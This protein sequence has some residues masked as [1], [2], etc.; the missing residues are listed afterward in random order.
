MISSVT[1]ALVGVEEDRIGL[2]VGPL[3]C[4]LLVPAV[5]VPQLQASIGQELTLFTILY[6]A[7]DPSRGS[8]EPTLIG[9]LRSADKQFF[10][11]FTTVKGIGPRKALRALTVQ[12]GEIAAAIEEKDARYLTRLEGIGKRMAE[13]IIAELA[14][15]V[16]RFVTAI[17]AA[18]AGGTSVMPGRR[19]AHEEDAIAAM[20]A[21]GE[22]RPDAEH[23][24]DRAKAA[25]P[26]VKT[27][28]ALLREMLRMRTVRA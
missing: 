18:T 22:R 5:D 28:D 24:L 26:S 8:L 16:G 7:G 17:P 4:E 2:Q 14:G 15:K 1:G 21:L 20:M 6:F 25:N 13:Q 3:V 10:E 11:Q 12:T 9:F 27:T 23:F 19:A